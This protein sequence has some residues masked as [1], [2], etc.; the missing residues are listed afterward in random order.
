MK[1]TIFNTIAILAVSF[2]AA[3]CHFLEVEQIGKSDING[4]FSEPSA[5]TAAV[6][7]LHNIEYSLIDKYM[8][9][10]PEV[11]S[12][13]LILSASESTWDLYQNF[14]TTS[15][16]EVGA[17]GYIWKLGY[18][19]INNANQII[20][21]VPALKEEYP[22]ESQSLD[23]GMAQALFVRAY[24][25]LCLCLSYGQNY[26]YTDDA[27]HLGVTVVTK[28]LSLNESPKRDKVSTVYK[29]IISDLEESL[30]WYP[31]G[32]TFNKYLPSPLSS[33]ALLA[34]V[35]LYMGNWTK[36]AEYA[37]SV[38]NKVP[39][40]SRENYVAMFNAMSAPAEDEM[41]YNLNGY[42]LGSSQY[43]MYWK[44]DPKARP[45]SR[46]TDL[47]TEGDVRI[48]VVDLSGD[49]VCLKFDQVDGDAN[50]YSR[51]PI[52]R[53]SEMYLIRAEAN[54]RLGNLS[55][56]AKDIEALQSRA[57]GETVTLGEMDDEE[58]DQ[59][60]EDERIK[61]LCFEGHRLWDITRRH[62]NLVRTGD[63][64]A[65]VKELT[66]PN[67]RFVLPIPSVELE[68]N[69]SMENNPFDPEEEG[70]EEQVNS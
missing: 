22:N 69:K 54:L 51:I 61:E 46:V 14:S 44:K 33:E 20:E 56:A 58:L 12:D 40:T 19:V 23:S 60:I 67:N 28:A 24:A 17:L 49:N 55:E 10:Y 30:K 48:G 52:L 13:E 57:M 26:T 63:N 29:Q 25:H 4:Y 64:T 5:V 1:K 11:A 35:Y 2:A 21:H 68:A 70:T 41:I 15:D 34:R 31:E 65:Q 45:S 27:S 50:A 36:A 59:A 9:L 7:G 32:F 18:Q 39:L 47:F 3:G 66:Y 53:A 43:K 8:I 6:Y 62:K 42:Q 16:D 37:T 38:I